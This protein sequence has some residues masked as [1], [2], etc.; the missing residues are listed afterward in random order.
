[1]LEN[2]DTVQN[3]K[4]L[5]VPTKLN[6]FIF[7]LE[8][9]ERNFILQI[10]KMKDSVL[11]YLNDKDDI[12]FND[13]SLALT[14]RYK[15]DNPISTQLLGDFNEETSKIIAGKLS[16]KLGKVVFLSFNLKQDR[17]LNPLLEKK[18][19]EEFDKISHLL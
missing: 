2:K 8:I 15:R 5:Y 13:F 17:R 9:L 10:I 16:K 11:I 3:Q 19:C 12:Q 1:M 18:I 4:I 7:D 14:D 6:N